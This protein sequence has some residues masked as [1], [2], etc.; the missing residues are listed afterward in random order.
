MGTRFK[1][2]IVRDEAALTN[3]ECKVTLRPIRYNRA[4]TETIHMLE[5]TNV[6]DENQ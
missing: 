2:P 4:N 1:Y 3:G 5:T 6:N